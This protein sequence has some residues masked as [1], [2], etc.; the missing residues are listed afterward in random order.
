MSLAR[1]R[2]MPVRGVTY[3]DSR[4]FTEQRA[5]RLTCAAAGPPVAATSF[6]SRGSGVRVPLAPPGKT[7]RAG[8]PMRSLTP[9]IDTSRQPFTALSGRH[10][11]GHR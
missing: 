11:G 8:S 7:I 1:A 6:A 10:G 4:S 9:A 3:G 2:H 5:V